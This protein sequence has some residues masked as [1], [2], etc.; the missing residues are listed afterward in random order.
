M[1]SAVKEL[2]LYET[3][4]RIRFFEEKSLEIFE[5]G[6]TPGRMHPYVGEEAAA[7]GVCAAL[8]ESD[9]IIGTHRSGGHLIAKG[10]DPRKLLAEYIGKESGYSKGKGGP[11]HF[12]IP[13]VGLLCTNG[14]VGSGITVAAGAALA[15]QYQKKHQVVCCFFGDGA[16]NTGSF[17]EGLNLSSLWKLPVV[18]VCENNHFAET[19]PFD[20]AFPIGDI[21]IRAAAYG[22]EGET[23]DG[24]NVAAVFDVTQQALSRARSGEG[25]TLIEA[26]TYR[27]GPHFSGESDHYRKDREEELR[28]WQ[29]RDPIECF[30]TALLEKGI[31]KTELNAID[32]NAKTEMDRAAN[33]A[34]K[35]AFPLAN[36]L[37]SDVTVTGV[38]GEAS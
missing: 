22:M 6:L 33:K 20:R 30:R 21:G 4:T 15:S 9:L 13:E 12:C 11:M 25:P 14:I 18:Y 34:K 23:I 35:D 36:S 24:N 29:E 5:E 38:K 2:Q 10:A 7:A 28:R 19:M 8:Q 27:V 26:K 31:S 3:M 37:V 17:H 32:V 1:K 16:S